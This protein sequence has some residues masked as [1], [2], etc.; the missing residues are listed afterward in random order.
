MRGQGH[1]RRRTDGYLCGFVNQQAGSV[2]GFHDCSRKHGSIE[3]V[4]LLTRRKGS[5]VHIIDSVKAFLV[6]GAVAMAGP[7]V[8]Q[9]AEPA[10]RPILV[11]SG[12]ITG[13]NPEGTA[14]VQAVDEVRR[15]S[16]R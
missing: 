2:A 3:C 1:D 6:L 14:L 12:K 9:T 10:D 13:T 8:A 5:P 16:A 4:I 7:S 15:R 11:I